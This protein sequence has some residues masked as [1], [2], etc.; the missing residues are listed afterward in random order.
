M[1]EEEKILKALSEKFGLTPE[2]ASIKR[3]RRI[4]VTVDLNQLRPALELLAKELGFDALATI[5]GMD[6]GEKL[7]IIYHLT[8][9]GSV[10][11]NLKVFVPKTLGKIK[12]IIDL[13]P[14]AELYE[15]EMVDLLGLAVEGLPPGRRYPLPDN[16]PADQHPLLKDWK[17]DDNMKGGQ[18]CG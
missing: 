16:W 15:R 11:V 6:S 3:A 4:N 7:E 13:Y 10:V 18:I 8:Q 12:T 5:T 14:P 1:P 2:Q 9:K 17:L